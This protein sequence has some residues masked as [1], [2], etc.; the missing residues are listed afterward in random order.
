M[1]RQASHVDVFIIVFS[2]RLVMP[3]LRWWKPE[4]RNPGDLGRLRWL[5]RICSWWGKRISLQWLQFQVQRK[6]IRS[7]H[8]NM[9][10]T[11]RVCL[12]GIWHLNWWLPSRYPIVQIPCRPDN[13][14]YGTW[15]PFQIP[16]VQIPHCPDIPLSTCDFVH[17]P[18]RSDPP[19]S[20]QQVF[21]DSPNPGSWVSSSHNMMKDQ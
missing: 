13:S 15:F 12:Q 17:F 19:L 1:K 14:L 16:M 4:N 11:D 10:R 9:F 8:R 7:L 18:L 21:L 5:R 6:F 3:K 20:R 2:V